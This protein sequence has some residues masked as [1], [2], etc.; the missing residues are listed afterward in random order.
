M[1]ERSALGLTAVYRAVSLISGVVATL[2]L[3]TYRD[4]PDGSRE[5]VR[6]WV[7]D[8]GGPTGPTPYEWKET[9]LA[10][11]LIHGEAFGL[12]LYGAAGNIVA[13]QLLHPRCVTIE[14]D[15]AYPGGVKYTVTLDDGTRRVLAAYDVTHFPALSTDGV[16]GL[17]PIQAARTS[18]GAGIAADK[19]AARMYKNG[20]M[21]GGLVSVDDSDLDDDQAEELQADLKQKLGG[22]KHAGDLAVVNA[23]LKFQSWSMSAV[24]AQFIESRGFQVEEVARLFGIPKVLLAEDGASTWG[25]G[26]AELIR[27]FQRFTLAQWTSRIEQRISQLLPSPRFV[28]FDYAGLLQPTPS[29][30]TTNM[31]AEIDAGLLTLDEAR[32]ILN[33]PALDA[34]PTPQEIP[35]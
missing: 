6:S 9:L 14:T 17:G 32:R 16:H 1:S 11:M 12:H 25:S 27:G 30:V 7:D 18:L 19:A 34:A 3:K 5:R 15:P 21:V 22:T 31:V 2:P 23:N 10:H 35:A 33:R 20:M 28:E 29:E 4:L 13:M 8:P 24:D 26:I